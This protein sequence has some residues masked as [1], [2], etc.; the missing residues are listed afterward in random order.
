MAW[1]LSSWL[2]LIR[3]FQFMG[4]L[5]AGALN[6]Y[7]FAVV[8]TKRLGLTNSMVV[9]EFLGVAMFIYTL[10]A[11]TVLHTGQRSKSTSWLVFFIVLDVKFCAISV[12]II[13]LLA[14]A[15]LPSN[16][17]GLTKSDPN[18]I[19][20][21]RPQLGY[22]SIGF[23]NESGDQKGEL[24]K[25]CAFERSYYF[26]AVGFI[27]TF[28]MTIV[29]SILRICE[30]SYTKNSR[31]SEMLES[32]E[33]ASE[34]DHKLLMTPASGSP[35]DTVAPKLLGVGGLEMGMAH[36]APS[37]GILTRNT[38]VR[39]AMT[40]ST[41][42]GNPY[43]P[44]STGAARTIPRR[45]VALP[46]RTSFVDPGPSTGLGLGLGLVQP[47]A[48]SEDESADAAIISDGMHHRQQREHAQRMPMLQ[49]EDQMV[50]IALVSDGMR[51][52]E[53]MLPPYEPRRG[54]HMVG[55]GSESNDMRLSDYVKGET[56][57]QAMKD[58]GAY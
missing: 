6:G 44:L 41:S 13:T 53:P 24:D 48:G 42:A 30:K 54:A 22:S 46:Q 20:N 17:G 28:I 33:R 37:E 4:A 23:T 47:M 1:E 52:S 19:D 55:H 12:A 2:V 5:G 7:L 27:F 29:L 16:C 40:A 9:L 3:S 18:S 14:S 31:V 11:M 56:R 32:L 50:D 8:S 45:P 38:S 39:S 57:A 34:K 49:E 43:R 26:I 10:F 51:P 21:R 25:F 58:S 15:G 35:H 36:W